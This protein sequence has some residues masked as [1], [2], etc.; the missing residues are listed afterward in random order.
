MISP[1]RLL[2]CAYDLPLV[3]IWTCR[4]SVLESL[5]ELLWA[6]LP[7]L[8]VFIYL[9]VSVALFY[10]SQDHALAFALTLLLPIWV[11][12]SILPSFNIRHY[13]WKPE[14]ATTR[15]RNTNALPVYSCC[16]FGL[17][18]LTVFLAVGIATKHLRDL[19]SVVV[20]TAAYLPRAT[21]GSCYGGGIKNGNSCSVL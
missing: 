6:A 21:H 14:S 15:Y 5:G 16:S 8:V 12:V 17:L 19:D 2:V 7:T 20:R 13:A 18:C 1:H 3:L 4:A 9:W 11:F 10:D